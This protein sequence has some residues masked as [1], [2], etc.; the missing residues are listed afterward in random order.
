MA[1]FLQG[2]RRARGSLERALPTSPMPC[3]P[4]P[5][6]TTG[7]GAWDLEDHA[8]ARDL[9]CKLDPQEP[10]SR[11]AHLRY[12]PPRPAAQRTRGY[13]S[14]EIA[15]RQ[16]LRGGLSL[17]PGHPNSSLRASQH[18]P[19]KKDGA[20][21]QSRENANGLSSGT[22]RTRSGK[23]PG[24]SFR[25]RGVQRL[26]RKFR[27]RHSG[28]VGNPNVL[29]LQGTGEPGA[30]LSALGACAQTGASKAMISDV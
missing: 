24:G 3:P 8:G 17:E 18:A 5:E 11:D 30:K 15:P 29:L 9:L 20:E 22:A 21:P 16:L 4:D 23:K 27:S 26:T 7:S 1:K 6:V 10:L 28:F 14:S 2:M 12:L 13:V 19:E 25:Q